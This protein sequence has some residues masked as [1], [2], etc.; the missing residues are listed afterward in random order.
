MNNPEDISEKELDK[1][2][3]N[4]LKG[5]L[6]ILPKMAG[7]SLDIKITKEDK[8]ITKDVLCYFM[9]KSK[10]KTKLD[11]RVLPKNDKLQQEMQFVEN[12]FA[13][14]L[15]TESENPVSEIVSS[16]DLKQIYLKYNSDKKYVEQA[17]EN[18]QSM[19]SA[20]I[21]KMDYLKNLTNFFK[22]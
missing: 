6:S 18:M 14:L 21:K 9:D 16:Y 8:K 11:N 12:L 13:D 3:K 5:L 22:P 1:I 17:H 7:E 4:L 2:S 19:M 10:E 15:G 20:I